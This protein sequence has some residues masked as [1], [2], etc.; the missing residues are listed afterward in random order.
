MAPRV[1]TR[2]RPSCRLGWPPQRLARLIADVLANCASDSVPGP[3]GHHTL[4]RWTGA[5]DGKVDA[6]IEPRITTREL[7]LFLTLRPFLRHGM[8]MHRRDLPP[9]EC[10]DVAGVAKPLINVAFKPTAVLLRV[11]AILPEP[12]KVAVNRSALH[13]VAQKPSGVARRVLAV[14]LD[15][16]CVAINSVPVTLHSLNPISIPPFYILLFLPHSFA[17]GLSHLTGP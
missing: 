6:Q 3:P 13:G 4:T 8:R 5:R 16:P 11:L 9:R 15:F 1:R 14:L 10:V 2:L 7:M 12:V 17:S